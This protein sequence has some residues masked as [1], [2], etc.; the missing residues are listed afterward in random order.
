L[1]IVG[2]D[3]TSF[4]KG[5]YFMTQEI[6]D[7]RLAVIAGA[8]HAPNVSHPEEFNAQLSAFLDNVSSQ[9]G[10]RQ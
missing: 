1:V 4:L 9:A 10:T 2:G 3:D 7:A 5:A 6:P 8:G